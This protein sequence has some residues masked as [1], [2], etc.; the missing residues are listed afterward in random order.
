MPPLPDAD[1]RSLAAGAME[2]RFRDA[3]DVLAAYISDGSPETDGAAEFATL[4]LVSRSLADLR[5]GQYLVSSGYPIQMYSVVRPV[6]ESLNLID[7]FIE[8]PEAAQRWA[9]GQWQEFTP[10][11][12]RARLGIERDPL[13]E[14]MSEHSHPRFAALQLSAFQHVGE[15]D[16][17]GRQRAILY[18]GEIPFD[19]PAVLIATVIPGILLA[20]LVLAAGHARLA[21]EAALGWSGVVRRVAQ[22]LGAGWSEVGA[23]LPRDEDE[24]VVAPLAFIKEFAAELEQMADEM[25]QLVAEAEDADEPGGG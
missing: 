7:L 6:A 18:T 8:E 15:P 9:D 17:E 20:K 22:E 11:R 19:V 12:I 3:A 24:E 25:E 23:A 2:N 5:W 21:R 10:A 13:Y 4:H 1:P 16:E 14:F